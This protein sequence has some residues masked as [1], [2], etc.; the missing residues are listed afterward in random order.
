MS[1]EYATYHMLDSD[2]LPLLK[3][4]VVIINAARGEITSTTALLEGLKSGKIWK[5]VIDVWENEPYIDKDLLKHTWIATP[6]IAGYSIDSKAIGTA[7]AV[8]SIADNLSINMPEIEIKGIPEPKEAE[9][10]CST[11]GGCEQMIADLLLFAYNI[12]EDDARLRQSPATFEKQRGDY[13][14]RREYG[15]FTVLC[16]SEYSDTVLKFG[17]KVKP[18]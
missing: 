5:T 2:I 11:T 12:R 15:A 8:K 9:I 1:G 10:T 14:V 3:D 17:F 16:P 6:H 18:V 13:P 4:N 7:M